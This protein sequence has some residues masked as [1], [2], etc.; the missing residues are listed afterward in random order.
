[1][2]KTGF[3]CNSGIAFDGQNLWLDA[4]LSQQIVHAD[5]NGNQLPDS[6]GT[7][8]FFAE[9]IAYDSVSFA[10][11]CALWANE[12]TFGTPKITAFEVPCTVQVG[13]ILNVPLFKQADPAWGNQE[14]DDGNSQDLLCGKTIAQCGCALTSV[15]MALAFHGVTKGP[16]G[17][18]TDPAS[19]NDYFRRNRQ[20]GQNGCISKGYRFGNVRWAAV[21]QY[22][23]EANAV[24]GTPKIIWNG[25]GGHDADTIRQDINDDR[26]VI[27]AEPGHFIV[28]TGYA[29]NTFTINDPG[30][31][32]TRLDDP[33]YGNSSLGLRRF[34]KT[35]SDFTSIEVVIM[36]PAQVLVGDANGNR[37]GFN[38]T[39]SDV[40]QEIPGSTYFFEPAL[41]DDTGE[42]PAPPP[43]AGINVV[44]LS[45]PQASTYTIEVIAPANERY[46]FAMYGS[47]RNSNLSFNLFEGQPATAAAQPRY[48]FIYDPTP[49]AKTLVFQVTLDIK[50][51]DTPNSINLK[52]KGV[53]P[54][55]IVS[56]D[57]F[58][59]K[60]LD[61]LSVRFGPNAARESHNKGHIE[62]VNGDGKPDMVLH[63]RTQE[64]GIKA[65][66]SDA[67]LTGKTTI[68]LDV[69]GCD[70]VK[71]V[72]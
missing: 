36:A 15:A 45:M 5:K 20:C 6:F 24:F 68:G 46:S 70:L 19:L 40:V 23:N 54:V 9:D 25:D 18:P 32:R 7:P 17:N 60:T 43:N 69:Q 57:T 62:D 13:K 37:T 16:N 11:K 49:G 39:A 34:A 50:P 63:F 47:D 64:S 52:S 22:S 72:Q 30:F 21:A 38:P 67:C 3:D 10:P 41:A 53:I 1:M 28:G 42:N 44:E 56:T 35:A 31:S 27:L 14:Y 61:P 26:P 59:A 2:S 4:V 65:G 71:I 48:T 58:D 8:G 12:A 55:A 51:G 33:A 29:G 66:D